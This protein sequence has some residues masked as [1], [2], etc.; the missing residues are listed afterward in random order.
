[1][2]VMLGFTGAMHQYMRQILNERFDQLE[3]YLSEL[4]SMDRKHTKKK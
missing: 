3:R 1:V 4:Q 2:I